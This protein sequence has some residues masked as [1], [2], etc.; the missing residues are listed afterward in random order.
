M[1]VTKFGFYKQIALIL[2][3][4]LAVPWVAF[5]SEV[6]IAVVDIT[7]PTDSVELEPGQEADIVI[8]YSVTGRQAN[9]ATFQVYT[10]WTLSGGEFTGSDLSEPIVVLAR[11]A[12]D[13]PTTGSIN[14][15]VIVA[16]DQEAGDTYRLTIEAIN[17][18]TTSPAALEAGNSSE[19]DVIV[20]S[21][22][23]VIDE[24]PP[25]ISLVSSPTAWT[26]GNVTITA[27]ITDDSAIVATKWAEGDQVTSFFADDGTDFTGSFTVSA[28][29]TYTVYAEDEYGNMAVQTITISNI[30]K[31]K[32][33]LSF[34]LDPAS[35]DGQNGW[36]ISPVSV[37]FT[38][39]DYESGIDNST[40]PEDF[41]LDTDGIH[42]Q[43]GP[44]SV[45]DIAGNESDP[46]FV[47]EIKIDQTAPQL[48]AF[49]ASP[50]PAAVNT[51]ITLYATAADAANGSG[52]WKYQYKYGTEDWTDFTPGYTTIQFSAAQVLTLY[53]QA[54][55]YAGNTSAEEEFILPVYDPSAGFVTGGGW[56]ISPAGASTDFLE[57]TGKANFGFVSKYQRGAHI[58]TGETHFQFKA[59]NLNFHSTEYEWLV[60]AGTKAQYKGSGTIN[61]VAGYK[62]MLFATDGG[63]KGTDTFRIRI[64]SEVNGTETVVYDNG[65]ETAL[66]G[67]SIVVHSK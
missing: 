6:D 59:G 26:N 23:T 62:F 8:N 50:S 4:L 9:S 52:V 38:A 17:I 25:S 30:D 20:I 55:D 47:P 22:T 34:I 49:Y 32:P 41:D 27:T 61:G 54:L 63:N 46:V 39:I 19:Y 12:K 65:N 28:N 53:C 64:W 42:P 51:P 67:G 3:L 1:S 66:G 33:V 43:S 13:D 29:S 11:E 21:A 37:N 58:P 10:V 60:I 40:V 44:Y 45:F 57:A 48:N 24:T 5:A 2:V 15:K 18:G 14:G 35:P 7:A 56:V 36:Y 16:G 31:I